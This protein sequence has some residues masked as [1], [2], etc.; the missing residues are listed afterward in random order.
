MLNS[1]L[2]IYDRR[3][4]DLTWFHVLAQDHYRPLIGPVGADLYRLYV[5]LAGARGI[6]EQL[7]IADMIQWLGIPHESWVANHTLLEF[8]GMIESGI[9]WDANYVMVTILELKPLNRQLL[10]AI[11]G[12]VATS[13]LLNEEYKE[14]FL[15]QINN[16]RPLQYWQA[17]EEQKN[18][19]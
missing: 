19:A 10:G 4:P 12:K 13:R 2:E 9:D 15:W 3:N 11:A 5:R 16:W 6:T 14:R 17:M 1:K 7:P 18:G 8:A